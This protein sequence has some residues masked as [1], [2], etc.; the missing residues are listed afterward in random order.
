VRRTGPPSGAVNKNPSAAGGHCERCRASSSLR[1]F[2]SATWRRAALVFGGAR[3][4]LPTHVE[5]RRS[6]RQAASDEIQTAHPQP[7]ERPE[8]V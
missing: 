4:N 3:L 5:E 2:G 1:N 7:G 6:D 8:Q